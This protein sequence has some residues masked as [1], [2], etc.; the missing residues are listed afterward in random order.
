MVY[1]FLYFTSVVS[2]DR[3]SIIIKEIYYTFSD[4]NRVFHYSWSFKEN[5]K[6]VENRSAYLYTI[7]GDTMPFIDIAFY[8]DM[9]MPEIFL[10]KN[11]ENSAF[12]SVFDIEKIDKNVDLDGLLNA[13]KYNQ[14]IT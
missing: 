2:V 9:I 8:N 4:L 10:K 12:L 7:H 14:L 11:Q 5:L 6:R 3:D 13:E 1:E